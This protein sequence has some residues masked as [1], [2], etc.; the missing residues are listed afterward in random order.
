MLSACLHWRLTKLDPFPAYYFCFFVLWNKE[1][2]ARDVEP[3]ISTR[4][5]EDAEIICFVDG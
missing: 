1:G 3:V 2:S 5:V 4:L